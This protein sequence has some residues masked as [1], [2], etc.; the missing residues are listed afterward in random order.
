M[1][2]AGNISE[3]HIVYEA[4]TLVGDEEEELGKDQVIKNL[5]LK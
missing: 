2:T 4:G 1:G 5:S 3:L